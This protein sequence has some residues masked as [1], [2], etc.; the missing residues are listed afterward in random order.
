[1]LD[2]YFVEA[3]QVLIDGRDG[4]RAV[5]LIVLVL[6]TPEGDSPQRPRG[7]EGGNGMKVASKGMAC[8]SRAAHHE[9][10]VSTL[11]DGRPRPSL[12]FGHL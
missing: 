2:G 5:P 11:W 1:V 4:L 12:E 3:P 7:H 10:Q 8:T 6:R 9:E